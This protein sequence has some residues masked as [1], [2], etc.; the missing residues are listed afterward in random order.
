[1]TWT[2]H[3]FSNKRLQEITKTK[4][5]GNFCKTQHMRYIAHVTRLDN[6]T[7]QKQILFSTNHKKYSRDR[8]IKL[9]KELSLSKMQIQKMMQNRKQFT[10]L[11]KKILL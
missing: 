10:S 1:M 3:I 7:L 8:W 11:V 5:I 6:D 2:G 4:D 9:E